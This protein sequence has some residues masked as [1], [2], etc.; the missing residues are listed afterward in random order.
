M[1]HIGISLFLFGFLIAGAA[2]FRALEHQKDAQYLDSKLARIRNIYTQIAEE[3]YENRQLCNSATKTQT[4]KVQLYRSLSQLSSRI[5][6][7]PFELH[8][9]GQQPTDEVS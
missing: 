4:W 1:P 2:T 3:I 6:N 5:E 8:P 9:D 7:R